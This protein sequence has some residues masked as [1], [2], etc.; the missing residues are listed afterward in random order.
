MDAR[1]KIDCFTH[2]ALEQI[3][4]VVNGNEPSFTDRGGVGKDVR[5]LSDFALWQIGNAVG[6]GG[7]GEDRRE[8]VTV[9][10]GSTQSMAERLTPTEEDGK[11]VYTCTFDATHTL[12]VVCSDDNDV[13]VEDATNII[14]MY[15]LQGGGVETLNFHGTTYKYRTTQAN[16][17]AVQDEVMLTDLFTDDYST[18][19]NG[20]L[21]AFNIANSN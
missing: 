5:Y 6:N 8:I 12:F 1:T 9:W 13:D 21:L 18:A 14:C 15:S 10:Y 17:G 20:V 19:S 7:G 16:I 2:E 11:T 4:D 3:K